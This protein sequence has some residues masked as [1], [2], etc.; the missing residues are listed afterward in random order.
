MQTL[1]ISHCV[2]RKKYG[3]AMPCHPSPFLAEIPEEFI[4][5]AE[6]K[7]RAPVAAETGRNLFS[8]LRQSIG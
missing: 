3:Q 4:E 2:T 6:E 1:T 8:A 7:A 5:H